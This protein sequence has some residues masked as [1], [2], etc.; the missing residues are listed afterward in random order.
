MYERKLKG[1]LKVTF[2]LCLLLCCT[3]QVLAQEK[4]ISLDLQDVTVKGALEQ[5]KAK[6]TYSLWFNVNDVDLGRKISISFQDKSIGQAL[7]LILKGQNLSYEIKDKY[8][9]IF[10]SK[11]TP[12]KVRV[13]AVAGI[14]TDDSGE[15][16]PGVSIR[17]KE[18]PSV[19]TITDYDGKFQLDVPA[20]AKNLVVSYIGMET[21]ETG[22]KD[23]T[24]KVILS[25]GSQMLEEVVVTGMTKVDKRLFTGATDNIKA[26]KARLDG[27]P[28]VSRA[29]EGR[30]AGVSVQNV[31]GTFGTAPK[32]RVRGATSIYGSSKPLWVV[33]GVVMEDAVE[34]S[35]DDL[36][37]GDAVTLISSAIAGL[38]ADDIESFQIL[39]DGSATSIYGA[40][41]MAG[42]VVIT[43]KRGQAGVNRI[44]YT[45]EFTSRLKP[46]YNDFN[47]MNSQDQ[48]GVYQE[49][50][51]KGWLNFAGTYRASNSGVYGK[52]YQMINSYDPTTGKWGLV[53]TPEARAQYLQAA[54][55]R[56]TDWFSELFNS[57]IM[58]NHAVSISSGTEKARFYASLS[59]FSDPGWTKASSVK[60]YTA[61]TN[62]SFSLS[63]NLTLNILSNG[64]YRKQKAPGTLSQEIDVVSGEVRRDFDINPYSYALNTSRTLS[65][66]DKSGLT[67]Y[68]RNYAPFN[69]LNE[70]DKNYICLDVVDLKFQ[71]ELNWKIIKGLEANVMG[72]VKYQLT[73]QEHNIE[74]KS[75][76]A[77]AY[78]AVGDATIRDKNPLLYKDP[79]MPNSLP[80]V[81]LPE[82]GIFDKNEYKML[83]YDFRA[84]LS[85]NTSFNNI[86]IMNLFAGTE[87]NS[88]DRSQYWSRGWGYQYDNGG[89]PFYDYLIF[90][91]GIEQNNQY[92]YNDISY[93]RN[94]AFFGMGTYSYMGKYIVNG[95]I[96]Y[97]GSNRLGKSMSARWLPTWNVALAWNMH[98]E[99]F[100]EK[101][102]SALSHF[103]LKTSYSLTADRGP[104]FVTNS[105]VVYRNYSPYRPFA[106]VKESGLQIEDLE[107]SELTYEKKHEFNIGADLGFLDNRINFSV[108]YYTRNNFDLIGLIN[109]QGAGG[110]VTKY[111]N[112]ASMKS[113]GFE[114]TLSTKNI[115]TKDFSWSTDFI[116]SKSK[117][118]ITE[119]DSKARVMS[120]IS[121]MGFAEKGYPVR[122]LFSIPFQGLNEDGLPT[123]INQDGDLTITD[124]NFQEI[125]KKGFLKYEGPTDPTITGSFGNIFSYKNFKLNVFITYSFGNV[126]RLDPVFKSEYSD[127]DAMP[128]EFKNRWTMPGDEA[129]TDVPVI[130]S[131]RQE[132]DISHLNYAY[133]AYNYSDIRVAD[134]D[135][136]RMKEISL[137]YD[138]TQA[139]IKKLK[140][141]NLQ[142]KLQATNLFLIYA[143][144][145]LNGQDPEFFRSGGVSS[146]VPKQF[147]LTLR[148]SL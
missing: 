128:K 124:I 4:N 58:M 19:G 6:T 110:Q 56:N 92:Y 76:Q 138:F 82:G 5:L 77:Q 75:N 63:K 130:A 60:R 40:R 7:D 143:D 98:E 125:Q 8:I 96:R 85:Y 97:E 55:M 136:I 15:S 145:K 100:F 45:G 141:N 44:S 10:K 14:V 115:Q 69:I 30:S 89:I 46:S 99:K 74:D 118:E 84:S 16:L 140:L 38:S 17:F 127:L 70:L 142:L 57:N 80:V 116:F 54:E 41:A 27:I 33:D 52:M 135:F 39:K 9:Q 108:D 66:Q 72:A 107:N 122:A 13:K 93:S 79:D 18:V 95:T 21:K 133:N 146:P 117:N 59:A 50:E 120:L 3:H 119:L 25:S 28:D 24:M 87:A 31:S 102:R 94:L 35:A 42:V 26:D 106:G 148:L 23:G 112:V 121:G 36:S 132:K 32:I 67:S 61:N 131:K 86:H 144:S 103:S 114:L 11:E 37:S 123:F 64:S 147:T 65:L 78:R 109:T 62:A 126:V 111:A 104:A 1:F 90:K 47:I 139:W 81:V 101:L 88:V 22:I 134:G 49:M 20:D 73:S 129:Y 83:G 51:Q 113:S 2:I 137:S 34:V 71:G 48:M 53:N 105:R 91:Q 29:L 68:T 12:T 43:T